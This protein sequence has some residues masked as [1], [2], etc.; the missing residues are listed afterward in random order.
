MATTAIASSNAAQA[1]QGTTGIDLQSFLKIVLTQLTYQDPLKPVDSAQFVSQL[2]QFTSLEQSRQLTEKVDNLLQVQASTQVIGL[3]GKTVEVA[4]T[5]GAVA[6]TIGVVT[7]V[8]FPG[9]SPQFS[10]RTADGSF[11][12]NLTLA[13]IVTVR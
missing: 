11:L 8:S 7:A 10:I 13:Q 9:G 2:A 4:G 6:N 3:L 5:S 12:A 1:A